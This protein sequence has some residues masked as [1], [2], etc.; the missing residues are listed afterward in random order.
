MT[1][2][3][4][5]QALARAVEFRDV[6]SSLFEGVDVTVTLCGL[7]EP[8]LNRDT[9][10]F[11]RKIT[12]A[13]F[14]C[15]LSSNA[16]FLDEATGR[17]LLDAGLHRIFINAGDIGA[18]YE[19][20]YELPFER[21]RDNVAR[22]VVMA[23]KR[24]HV[25]IVIVGHNTDPERARA[26]E[27]YWRSLGVE[28]FD[29][30]DII[31]RGGSLSVEGMGFASHPYLASAQRL[32]RDRGIAP[33]CA[34][35]FGFLF[36]GYD[37]QYYLCSSDWEK[38]VPLGNVFDE[39]FTSI[40]RAKLQHVSTRAPI[41]ASCCHDPVNRLAETLRARALAGDADGAGLEELLESVSV[42]ERRVRTIVDPLLPRIV[43]TDG[44][45]D[46]GR[47]VRC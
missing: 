36:V 24:T 34:V 40:T 4:F 9:P 20:V 16:S 42:D 18:E 3:V 28:R 43:P 38:R 21:T 41:C 31:N 17:A 30:H 13:G 25:M 47:I 5:E 23:R 46:D 1:T 14:K 22:F 39:S 8:L 32:L 45:E 37:G 10:T 35:A 6:A 29:H 27:A 15:A 44:S 11:V 7:G 2:V 33:I 26:V 19:R 12:E